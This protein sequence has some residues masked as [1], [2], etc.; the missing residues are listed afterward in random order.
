MHLHPANPSVAEG[1][2]TRLSAAKDGDQR[3]NVIKLPDEDEVSSFYCI[4]MSREKKTS[5]LSTREMN[6][7]S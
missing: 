5:Y 1:V 2:V 7:I 3:E 4:F 6:S